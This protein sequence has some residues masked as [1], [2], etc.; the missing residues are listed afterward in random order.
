MVA[1]VILISYDSSEESVGSSTSQVILFGRIPN[2]IPI[3]VST[4]VPA[5]P[6]V[7]AIVTHGRGDPSESSGYFFDSDSPDSL[8]LPDSHETVVARWRI[9][10]ALH[11]SSS[12]TSSPSTPILPSTTITSHTLRQIIPEPSGI[13]RRHAILVLPSQEIPFGRSYHTHPDGARML[14]TARKRVH[15]F[16]ARILAN[17]RRM[18]GS[19][20]HLTSSRP[21]LVFAVCMCVRYQAKPTEKHL[22]AV[23][24]IFRYL[25]R[26][27]DMGLWY[28]KDS[29]ITLTAYADADHAG[30]QDTGRNTSRSA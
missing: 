4:T 17:R 22:H 16:L 10:V 18:I 12:E 23:K 26:T 13:P 7:M 19:L 25:K 28:S 2:V 20:M 5:V 24:R 27:I 15:P 14:L 8:S 1:S 9:K 6:E 30:C 21:D 3:D 11:S 29:C